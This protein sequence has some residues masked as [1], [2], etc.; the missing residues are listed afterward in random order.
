LPLLSRHGCPLASGDDSSDGKALAPTPTVTRR[1]GAEMDA[2]EIVYPPR[3]LKKL[4]NSCFSPDIWG[5]NLQ[6]L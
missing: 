1:P 5:E 3:K 6:L 4:R 2:F